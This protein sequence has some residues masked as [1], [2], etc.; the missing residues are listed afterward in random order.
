MVGVGV[1]IGSAYLGGPPTSVPDAIVQ[2]FVQATLS[3]AL[4]ILMIARVEAGLAGETGWPAHRELV[5]GT[6]LV[7]WPVRFLFAGWVWWS[8]WLLF[9]SSFPS[10]PMAALVLLAFAI[11]LPVAAM[12]AVLVSLS[13]LVSH[14]FLAVRW[15]RAGRSSLVVHWAW[16][17]AILVAAWGITA[18]LSPLGRLPAAIAWSGWTFGLLVIAQ[19]WGAWLRDHHEALGVGL[20][21]SLAPSAPFPF[22]DSESS[23]EAITVRS[24]PATATPPTAT[25]APEGPAPE[26]PVSGRAD[27]R[28]IH[29]WEGP[30][31]L[32]L[33]PSPGP[34]NLGAADGGDGSA[35]PTSRNPPSAVPP[36]PS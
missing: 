17:T 12:A 36:K 3:G 10:H 33:D 22:P 6:R 9:L 19:P 24:E 23:P 8:G 15:L 21:A 7:G 26:G 13:D 35:A 11:H 31:G 4:I 14:P 32:E 25:V 30:S 28:V 16:T 29:G 2:G 20:P 18:F 27:E 5:G 34:A 1:G